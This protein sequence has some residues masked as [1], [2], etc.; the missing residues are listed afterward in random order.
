MTHCA[1]LC[2]LWLSV[3]QIN[4]ARASHPGRMARGMSRLPSHRTR[5]RGARFETALTE[6]AG[7]STHAAQRDRRPEPAEHEGSG[8]W[9]SGSV[10]PSEE[11]L[12]RRPQRPR[13]PSTRH[14]TS[15]ETLQ[16]FTLDNCRK[17][18][19]QQPVAALLR[20]PTH[21]LRATLLEVESDGNRKFQSDCVEP[22]QERNC[23]WKRKEKQEKT[24]SAGSELHGRGARA[25]TRPHH[26]RHSAVR[27]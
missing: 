27:S 8:C 15:C 26:T 18:H 5:Q 10:R 6:N 20:Q 16:Q 23:L 14:D 22:V 19:A 3:P 24:R 9:D 17:P 13:F 1:P 11:G 12:L 25:H 7:L 4:T 21:A 2:P